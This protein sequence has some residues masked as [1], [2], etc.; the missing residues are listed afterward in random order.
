VLVDRPRPAD[1]GLSPT[2][3]NVVAESRTANLNGCFAE[4]SERTGRAS[5][6]LKVTYKVFPDGR[7]RRAEVSGVVDQVL[8]ECVS[9]LFRGMRYPQRDLTTSVVADVGFTDGKTTVTASRVGTEDPPPLI[10][11]PGQ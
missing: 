6:F 8:P 1:R 7:A 11:S 5:V 9:S 3:L 4:W 2:E 10:D